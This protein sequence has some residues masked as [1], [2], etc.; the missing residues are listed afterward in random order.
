MQRSDRSCALREAGV[1]DNGLVGFDMR[2]KLR[3]ALTSVWYEWSD[4]PWFVI[5]II[6]LSAFVGTTLLFGIWRAITGLF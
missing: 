2:S 5:L 1:W 6:A 3:R 4:A